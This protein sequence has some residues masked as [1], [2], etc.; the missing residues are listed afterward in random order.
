MTDLYPSDEASVCVPGDF[1]A[2][3]R[4]RYAAG[5]VGEGDDVQASER[6]GQALVVASEATAAGRSHHGQQHTLEDHLEGG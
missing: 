6:L 3:R 2:I 4:L 1:E 5:A